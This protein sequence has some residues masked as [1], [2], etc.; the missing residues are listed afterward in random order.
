M[1]SMHAFYHFAFILQNSI[2]RHASV[3][4]IFLWIS[5]KPLSI[6]DQLFDLP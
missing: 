5:Y 1:H 2:K 4:R 3:Q 6:M